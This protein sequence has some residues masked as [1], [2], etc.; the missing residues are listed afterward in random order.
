MAAHFEL[1]KATNGKSHERKKLLQPLVATKGEVILTSQMYASRA[2]AKKD[3][4][5]VK[6]MVIRIASRENA[7]LITPGS[8]EGASATTLIK[9]MQ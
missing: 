6:L 9:D 2:S 7:Q 5:S 4:A 1:K 8:S 3:I